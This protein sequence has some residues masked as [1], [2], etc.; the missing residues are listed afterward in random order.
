MRSL[1]SPFIFP[2]QPEQTWSYCPERDFV[3][4]PLLSPGGL[5]STAPRRVH[6]RDVDPFLRRRADRSEPDFLVPRRHNRMTWT[7][8][9]R[10]IWRFEA[11]VVTPSVVISRLVA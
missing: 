5:V 8:D 9:G 11:P 4:A 10:G 2:D 1:N 3:P 6:S 7:R